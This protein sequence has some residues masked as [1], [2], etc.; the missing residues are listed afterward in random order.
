MFA[1]TA[2]G[3]EPMVSRASNEC[4]GTSLPWRFQCTGRASRKCKQMRKDTHISGFTCWQERRLLPINMQAIV[5]TAWR[6]TLR[7]AQR[8]HE[9]PF[10]AQY[11]TLGIAKDDQRQHH[12]LSAYQSRLGLGLSWCSEGSTWR[13]S[14]C[15]KRL[16]KDS[17]PEA[18]CNATVKDEQVRRG[19]PGG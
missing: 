16:S 19:K 13:L 18:S 12:A 1:T 5:L 14:R 3:Q 11:T 6:S 10:R 9:A 8:P 15:H 7:D 17:C 4:P 2:K